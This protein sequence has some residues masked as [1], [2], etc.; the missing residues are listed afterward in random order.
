MRFYRHN[1]DQPLPWIFVATATLATATSIVALVPVFRL[2]FFSSLGASPSRGSVM[3]SEASPFGAANI[4]SDPCQDY[5]SCL[6]QKHLPPQQ[7]AAAELV[8]RLLPEHHHLFSLHL[9]QQPSSGHGWFSVE[10]VK[11]QI[12][13]QGTSGVEL[14][15]GVHWFLKYFAACSMSWNST[16]GLQLNHDSF[17]AAA[18][19][20]IEA[21]GKVRIERAV[22]FSFYQ[23][24]VTM[25]YSMAF[26][27][28]DRWVKGS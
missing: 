18:L 13:V 24:V 28:W 10:A 15:S 2:C 20:K 22:P 19:A 5:T 7:V 14:A 17:S 23:N 8:Q 27:D 25:S 16:G 1:S 11:G 3:P 4:D 9:Q 6:D 26:W 12:V 21:K